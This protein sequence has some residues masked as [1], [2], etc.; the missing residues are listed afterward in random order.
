MITRTS[1]GS[2]WSRRCTGPQGHPWSLRGR[3][4]RHRVLWLRHSSPRPGRLFPKR[5]RDTATGNTG[6]PSTACAGPWSSPCAVVAS[7]SVVARAVSRLGCATTLY[8]D[9]PQLCTDH[10]SVRQYNN[11][12]RRR[13]PRPGHFFFLQK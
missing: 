11:S 12:V 5:L 7:V 1:R 8:G 4:G 10:N 6:I 3:W 9:R 2:S 13:G